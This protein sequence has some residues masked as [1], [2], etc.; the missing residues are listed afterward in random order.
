[1]ATL[2]D[3]DF[4]DQLV[5]QY[6]KLSDPLGEPFRANLRSGSQQL[7]TSLP[8]FGEYA[9]SPVFSESETSAELQTSWSEDTVSL[10]IGESSSIE[11]S[12]DDAQGSFGDDLCQLLTTTDPE[13]R[14]H[15]QNEQLQVD[16]LYEL[17]A[18]TNTQA[19]DSEHQ[20]YEQNEQ[21]QVDDLYELV[22]M[23]DTQAV[24]PQHQVYEQIEQILVDVARPASRVARPASRVT[25]RATRQPLPVPS[26]FLRA[27][28]KNSKRDIDQACPEA[29]LRMTSKPDV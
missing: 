14:V 26:D 24:E 3:S 29:I 21:L 28:T 23:T 11:S 25:R 1:M 7:P 10:I 4:L 27:T 18:M 17:V 5:D 13:H 12:F 9:M 8:F 19:A 6:C 20:V 22:A 2:L 15:E 16:D